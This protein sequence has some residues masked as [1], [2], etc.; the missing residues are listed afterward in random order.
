MAIFSFDK[1]L[2][3]ARTLRTSS[4][5]EDKRTA[6]SRAYYAAFHV[7]RNYLKRKKLFKLSPNGGQHV[8]TIS[9]LEA[10]GLNDEADLLSG[11]RSLRN[12]ADYDADFKS[13]I[14]TAVDDALLDAEKLI[15]KIRQLP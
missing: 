2:A 4:A 11:L 1:F 3:Q 6:I 7:C 10:N 9:S 14:N 13:D 15:N 5:E 8:S 12:K